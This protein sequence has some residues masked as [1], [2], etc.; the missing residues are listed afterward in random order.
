MVWIERRTFIRSVREG[1]CNPILY[2][3]S[4]ILVVIN[5]CNSQNTWD[6]RDDE[7]SQAVELAIMIH[8]DVRQA[9]N[10]KAVRRLER[11]VEYPAP[12]D[13]D[14]VAEASCR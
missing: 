8:C 14:M 2:R 7:V 6:R 9:V 12:R 5:Q 11:S 10:R 1:R 4:V 3:F 13:L